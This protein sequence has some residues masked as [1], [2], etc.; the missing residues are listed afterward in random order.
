M[1]VFLFV[2]KLMKDSAN[3]N[4]I[5]NVDMKLCSVLDAISFI[6]IDWFSHDFNYD[7][8]TFPRL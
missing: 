6:Q 4:W 5:L 3:K 7:V 8:F 2:E 1:T